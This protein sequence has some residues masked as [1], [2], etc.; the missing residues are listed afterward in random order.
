VGVLET[1]LAPA[2]AGRID[3]GQVLQVRMFSGAL[4]SVSD[5]GLFNGA[6][7]CAIGD[8]TPDGWEVMQFRDAELVAPNTYHI[9]HRLR[10]Q[11]G[12]ERAS[13]WPVGSFIVRLD[14]SAKQIELAEGKRGLARFYRI[15][16]ATRPL[17][18]PSYRAARLAFDGVGLR[19][20]SPVHLRLTGQAGSGRTLT[21]VRRTRIDGDG[22]ESLDVPLGED[23]EAYLIR[24]MQNN[25]LLREA[26]TTAPSWTYTAAQQA[27]DALTGPY[28]ITVAQISARFGPGRFAALDVTG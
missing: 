26:Q 7:L 6:N 15:G 25:A 10:G 9:G 11:L 13:E 2:C 27:Q 3:R 28:Q 12:T 20:L 8:G 23:T 14:G 4:E 22:W 18:D 16:P 17:D 5:L 21:W 24:V 1:A 19:P